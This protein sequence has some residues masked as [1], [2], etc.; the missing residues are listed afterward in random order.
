MSA[1]LSKQ[2]DMKNNK[3][4]YL[5]GAIFGVI[6]TLVVM[7]GFSAILLFGNIDRSFATPFATVSVAVGCF[8]AAFYT[9]NKIKDKGYVIGLIVGGITFAVITILSLIFGKNGLSVNT[10]FHFVIIMLSSL[11]GGIVG[12][13]SKKS[14]KY[15]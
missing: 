4:F 9:S 2:D 1:K 8:M 13:N 12:V 3:K 7:L 11:A 10:L 5:W 14:K 6:L 15:I